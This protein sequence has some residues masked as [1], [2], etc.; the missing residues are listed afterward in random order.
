MRS[1]SCSNAMHRDKGGAMNEDQLRR[2]LIED[3]KTWDEAQDEIDSLASDAYD[4]EQ[5]RLAEEHFRNKEQSK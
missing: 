2:R 4:A 5:D 3:G 1:P